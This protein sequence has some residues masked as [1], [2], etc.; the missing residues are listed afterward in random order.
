MQENLKRRPPRSAWKPGTSGNPKG[1]PRRPPPE[2]PPAPFRDEAS[3]PDQMDTV[4][5]V[6][7]VLQR[8]RERVLEGDVPSIRLWL[9][10]R[11][12]LPIERVLVPS[13]EE[14]EPR[15]MSDEQLLAVLLKGMTDEQRSAYMAEMEVKRQFQER[16]LGNLRTS[17]RHQLA[18]GSEQ[19]R[20]ETSP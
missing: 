4:L 9:S 1:R 5:D 15:E 7:A 10:Y 20:P 12:G 2:P 14:L 8:L 16:V 17:G 19:A 11:V 18:A 3:L 6:T 13:L